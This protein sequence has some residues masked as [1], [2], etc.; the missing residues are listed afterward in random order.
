MLNFL[1]AVLALT[2]S[3]LAQP[4]ATASP[5]PPLGLDTKGV[6]VSGLSSGGYM[7][8]QFEVAHAASLKGAAIVAAGPY[9]CSM[10]SVFTAALTCSCPYD[11]ADGSGPVGL[12]T[13]VARLSCIQLP[14]FLLSSRAMV[15]AEGNRAF[16]DPITALKRHRV[17]L[18]S[19]DADPVVAPG[20]VDGLQ[21]FYA[22]VKVPARQIKRVKG[23]KAGHGMPIAGRGDCEITRS[24]YLNGC[25]IDGA[26][27]LLK[28][29]YD[30]PAVQPGAAQPAAMR[31]FDQT[32][33]RQDGVFDGMDSTGW[34]YVPQRCEQAN[35]RCKL[36]VVF[37]GCEQGQNFPANGLAGA[38]LYGTVFVDQAGYNRWA[39]SLG[40]VVLYPQVVPSSDGNMGSPFRYNPKGCWDFWG[41]TSPL[42]DASLSS[43]R[44]PFAR[45]DAPQMRAVKSMIDALIQKPTIQ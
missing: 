15:A 41:Y 37:H 26:G 31:P 40:V 14:A 3:A 24:P 10:G 19:G 45:K 11:I 42:G 32:P 18:Y 36:H 35:A 30:K 1:I 12:S 33:Y 21:A 7:A 4:P 13:A 29:L 44:P 2:G 34:V 39:E 20:I 28:W 27:E 8:A 6:T 16:I 25:N 22:A 17:W 5:L 9:G 38:P 23:P 43:T